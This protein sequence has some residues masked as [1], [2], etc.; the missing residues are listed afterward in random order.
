MPGES[1]SIDVEVVDKVIANAARKLHINALYEILAG[2]VEH[3]DIEGKARKYLGGP[4]NHTGS[5]LPNEKVRNVIQNC[6]EIICLNGPYHRMILDV[7][8]S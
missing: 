2:A 4:V 8:Q 6:A 7:L 1:Q 5:P 3:S